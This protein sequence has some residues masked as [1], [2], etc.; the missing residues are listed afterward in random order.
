M[1]I[2]VPTPFDASVLPAYDLG[3]WWHVHGFRLAMLL[4]ASLG[5][6]FVARA[7]ALRIVTR[8]A[9]ESAR[10]RLARDVVLL[11]VAGAGTSAIAASAYAVMTV[12]HLRVGVFMLPAGLAFWTSAVA[13]P[14]I[15]LVA[16]AARG[17]AMRAAVA[18]APLALAG[19]MLFGEPNRLEIVRATI[20]VASLPPGTRIRLAHLSDLQCIHVGAREAEAA[21]AVDAFD[22]HFVGFTGDLVADRLHP[23]LVAHV[24]RWLSSLRTRTAVFTVN[25]DCDGDFASLVRD[26]PGV[27]QLEDEGRTLDVEGARLWIAGVDNRRR[28]PDPARGLS[29]APPGSTRI[30][31]THNPD[32]FIAPGDWRAEVGLAG[33]THGGQVLVPGVGALVTFTKLGGRYAAG[34]FGPRDRDPALPWKVDT[35]V[36]CAGL[37]M[38]GGWAPRIRLLRPPQVMLLTLE[39][40]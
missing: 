1:R 30:L 20:P 11:A 27:T 31:L 10:R 8:R 24:R 7:L 5:A 40:P 33:H 34:V 16:A 36:V 39:G 3:V 32:R 22:P 4:P 14:S 18:L 9:G 2:A 28:P 23:A 6:A 38:E 29:G 35:A 17:E 21:A 37:G 13:A 26:L 19:W 25:G 12:G 15:A